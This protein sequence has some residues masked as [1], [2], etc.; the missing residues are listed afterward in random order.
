MSTTALS[1]PEAKN[2]LRSHLESDAFRSQ[3]A[4]VLPKHV[5]PERMVRV[6]ITTMMRTP[7]LAECT[8]ASFFNAMLTLSQ[9]GL[10]PDGRR[11]HLIPFWRNDK[12][13]GK[14][15]LECQLIIDWK[16]YAELIMRSGLVSYLHADVICENDTFRYNT[17]QIEAHEIDFRKPR[18]SV[19]AVYALCKLRDGSSKA[20]VMSR[21]DIESIRR[22]SRSANTGPWVTDWNEMA[23]KTVFRRLSKWLPLSPEFRDA[24]DKD[25]DVLDIEATPPR[26]SLASKLAP[27]AD[28]EPLPVAEEPASPPAEY[29][30]E[31]R[32]TAVARIEDKILT[33]GITEPGLL[34]QAKAAG[35]EVFDDLALMEQPTA[36][37][38]AIAAL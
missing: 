2:T 5:T 10:E 27:A 26:P 22:R 21:D 16:G 9:L 12:K 32:E 8:Q 23:K 36:T 6:A 18:G 20:D 19:Y 17:G 33:D 37:L 14:S 1:K 28:P 30:A 13:T 15:F 29:T 35:I 25:Q 34:K 11:A 24:L 3:I 38:V 31:D 4:L 7:D